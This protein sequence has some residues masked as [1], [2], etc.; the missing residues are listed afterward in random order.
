M[1][2][3]VAPKVAPR[4]R[5][6][7][8]DDQALEAADFTPELRTAI[9]SKGLA[10]DVATTVKVIEA[11]SIWLA[12]DPNTKLGFDLRVER[13][14]LSVRNAPQW[15]V[16]VQSKGSRWLL[17]DGASAQTFEVTINANGDGL[18][19]KQLIA[20]MA[21]KDQSDTLEYLD[22]ACEPEG[23][24]YVLSYV[25]PGDKRSDYRLDIYNPDG[26]H[27]ARTPKE[28]T[29]AD[30]VNAAKITVDHWRTLFTLNYER[31]SGPGGRP[32][33]S[34]SQWSPSAPPTSET[35]RLALGALE[36]DGE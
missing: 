35:E 23:F 25:R 18:K 12:E 6:E 7:E 10:L 31:I 26:T 32:E 4:V 28:G 29:T 19:A 17:R 9:A 14:D 33:P 13:G 36:G 22:L 1:Q 16:E 2:K 30:G 15:S 24:I 34:I 8:F 5:L 3:N 20:T 11:R 27:L 21:L